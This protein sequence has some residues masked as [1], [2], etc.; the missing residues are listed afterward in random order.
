MVQNLLDMA[1]LEGGRIA[2][3]CEWQMLEEV[4]GSAVAQLSAPLEPFEV[5]ISISSTMP[6]LRFDAVLIERVLFNLLDN[7]TKYARSGSVIRVTAT[8]LGDEALITVEDNG[9]GIPSAMEEEI[10]RKFSRGIPESAGGGTGLGLSICRAIIEAH[11]GRIWAENMQRGGARF[12]LTLPL[13]IPP[14]VEGASDV[15]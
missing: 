6:L 11:H 14:A 2:L 10:F 12:V 15:T 9:P 7:A 8:T 5:T 3:R 13:G 4:V 1:R